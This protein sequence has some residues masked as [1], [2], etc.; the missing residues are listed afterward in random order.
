[1]IKTFTIEPVRK[2]LVVNATQAH[3]FDVFTNRLDSWWP[4]GHSIGALPV[5]QS[6]IEP[7]K[8]GRWYTTHDDGSEC[9]VGHMKVWE[10]PHR[11]VFSW[12]ISAD[13]K[14]DPT[15]ASEVEIIFVAQDA[16][17]TRVELEHRNFEALGEKGGEKMRGGVEGGWSGLLEIFRKQAEV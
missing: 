9:V 1:M 2:M 12:E 15:V 8:G 16:R 13:W 3:A 4:K 10:P 11:I 17:T 14:P 7:R 5:K 6:F